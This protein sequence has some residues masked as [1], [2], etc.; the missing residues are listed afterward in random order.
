MHNKICFVE[1]SSF[2]TSSE[3][4]FVHSLIKELNFHLAY[5]LQGQ[6]INGKRQ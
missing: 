2:F 6:A 1:S 4:N 5:G 3:T